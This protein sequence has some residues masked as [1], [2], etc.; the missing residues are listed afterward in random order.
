WWIL[1]WRRR[2]EWW[3]Q[4]VGSTSEGEWRGG[5]DRSG[6]EETF[7]FRRKDPAGKVS[8]GGSMV[9]A[10]AAAGGL[11]WPTMVLWEREY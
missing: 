9:A 2:V 7:G 6:D 5:S 4:G 3:Q 11:G 8:G 1:W 10:V